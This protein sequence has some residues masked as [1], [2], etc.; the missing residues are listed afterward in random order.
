MIDDRLRVLVRQHAETSRLLGVDFVPAYRVGSGSE[1]PS[2]VASRSRTT[3]AIE[4]D[5]TDDDA[6]AG[7][8]SAKVRGDSSA[9]SDE[10]DDDS[11]AALFPSP[12]PTPGMVPAD[13]AEA[14]A[15]LDA[16]RAKYEKDAPHRTFVTKFKN[17][18]FGEGDPK[19]RIMFIGEAPGEEEDKT[20]RPFV[21]R[22]GQLLDK[23]IVAMGLKREDVYI[24][25]VLKTR[26]IDN[27]TPTNDEIAACKP[28]LLEQVAIISPIAI[29]SLGKPAAQCLLNSTESMSA[30][31]GTWRQIL[32]LDGRK[33]PVMP[34]FHPAFLLRSYTPDNRAKV[35]SDL[36]KV[37]ERVGIAKGGKQEASDE[38]PA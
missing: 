19:A 26:P 10:I 22:A 27:A 23:M 14:Q 6:G 20:G 25:N 36:Q 28:Y 35:W 5:A 15:A 16:L 33:V 12:G 8:E 1:S 13:R 11:N 17:I 3:R 30:M 4:Q 2:A 21:G 24:A 9:S 31:R 29:V 32:L 34:T 18:V 7:P 37:M 38:G